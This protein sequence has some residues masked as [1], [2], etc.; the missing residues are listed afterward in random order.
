MDFVCPKCRGT[1]VT[2]D[3]ATARCANHPGEF[4]IL[5]SRHLPPPPPPPPPIEAPSDNAP[6]D[7]V[8]TLVEGATCGQHPTQV[9]AHAC[10]TCGTPIC[11]LCAF[12]DVARGHICPTCAAS[13]ARRAVQQQPPAIPEGMRCVQ[14][15][16]VSATR[17]CRACGG[18][19]CDTC[20]FLLPGDIHVCPS[21]AIAP[22]TKLSSSRR[23]LT[24]ASCALAV[25]CTLFTAFVM[26]GA[27]ADQLESE[28]QQQFF[29]ILFM[30]LDMVPALVGLAL[31]LSAIDRRLHN[32]P[33]L[34]VAV[35]WNG[36]I[37]AALI[38]LEI[39]GIMRG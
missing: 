20:D 4:R 5:F 13:R 2:D 12:E 17:Q 36:L 7:M 37:T 19:M 21:C 10:G 31:G 3:G 27:L 33:L 1:L 25:W 38:L 39:I 6:P 11:T 26:S 9:A 15:P 34:W 16:V 32:P 24:F 23:K 29:G 28:E 35:I 14:H 22:R 30:L 8:Y 18:Y